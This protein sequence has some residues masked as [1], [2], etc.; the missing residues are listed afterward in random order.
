M[1]ADT[2]RL[3]RP[4]RQ[5]LSDAQALNRIAVVLGSC[6]E[7]SSDMLES[8]ALLVTTTGRP[9]VGDQTDKDLAMYRRAAD[10]LGYYHDGEE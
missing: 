7:W 9:P 8:I 10:R 1:T 3:P 5:R 4:H 6:E 2:V